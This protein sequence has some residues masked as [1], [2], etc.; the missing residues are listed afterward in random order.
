VLQVSARAVDFASGGRWDAVAIGTVA[1]A[2]LASAMVLLMLG[3]GSYAVTITFVVLYGLANGMLAVSRATTPLVF[4]DR[5]DYVRAASRMALPLNMV[6]AVAPTLF[7]V[8]LTRFGNHD[9]LATA[10][11]S[12]VASVILLL[13][14]A[15]RRPQPGQVA[16]AVQPADGDR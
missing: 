9:M 11:V 5:A 10:A 4:Y 8:L 15:R 7:I 6:S 13:V 12:M 3:D 14:L 1:G 16:P 2:V